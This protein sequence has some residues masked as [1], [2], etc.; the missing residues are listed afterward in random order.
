VPDVSAVRA[1]DHAGAALDGA[2][3]MASIGSATRLECKVCW[4]VY[5][6]SIGDPVWQIP[7]DTPWTELPPH[8]TCPNCS[9]MRDGFL[10]LPDE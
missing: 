4:Y 2:G 9:T 8:W 7:P 3:A 5:D 6:P 10:V 1:S